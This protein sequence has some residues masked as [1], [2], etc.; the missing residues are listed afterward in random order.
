MRG[1][2]EMCWKGSMKLSTW[3]EPAP[4]WSHTDNH[5]IRCQR[6]ESQ[7]E[8]VSRWS[9][10][11]DAIR[12][13]RAL[14]TLTLHQSLCCY[15]LCETFTDKTNNFLSMVLHTKP[16]QQPIKNHQKRNFTQYLNALLLHT[17]HTIPCYILYETPGKWV[18]K[19]DFQA[20]RR[21]LGTVPMMASAVI[22][23]RLKVKVSL[24]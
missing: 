8:R 1:R 6:G 3:W 2:R 12:W 10:T 22:K 14:Q 11:L 7:V 24:L 23:L 4:R 5:S 13:L 20:R 15:L 9:H 19:T 18:S 16:K 17:A 21:H